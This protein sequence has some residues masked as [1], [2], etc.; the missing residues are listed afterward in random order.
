MQWPSLDT[1]MRR[2][3]RQ[4]SGPSKALSRSPVIVWTKHGPSEGNRSKKKRRL[5]SSIL[6][7]L[8]KFLEIFAFA[9]KC[10]IFCI[11]QSSEKQRCSCAHTLTYNHDECVKVFQHFH[12]FIKNILLWYELILKKKKQTHKPL[13]PL[14]T[15]PSSAHT[16]T[17]TT[18]WSCPV[19]TALGAG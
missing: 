12:T 8:Q 10:H 3:R 11:L 18:S 19:S 7:T 2:G 1:E 13:A 4:S 6:L 14:M 17:H 9:E 5:K 16:D 15:N